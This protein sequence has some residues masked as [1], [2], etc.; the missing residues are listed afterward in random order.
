M[1]Y[2]IDRPAALSSSDALSAGRH[3]VPEHGAIHSEGKEAPPAP[4]GSPVYPA[5]HVDYC[6]WD[7]AIRGKN[8][9]TAGAA[10]VAHPPPRRNIPGLRA[11]KTLLCATSGA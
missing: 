3:P 8:L 10:P 5:S 9:R 1:V 7:P 11:T 4:P 6:R 2:R